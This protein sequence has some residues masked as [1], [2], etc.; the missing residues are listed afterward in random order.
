VLVAQTVPVRLLLPL[1]ELEAAVDGHIALLIKAL[2]GLS[3]VIAVVGVLGLGSTLSMNILERTREL[4]V[5]MALGATPKRLRRWI[6]AEGVAVAVFG[7]VLAGLLSLLVT[8]GLDA[9]IGSL[10][11]MAPLPFVLDGRAPAV[12]LAIVLASAFVASIVPAL[13]LDRLSVREA[14]SEL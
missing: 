12:W 6:V 13:R 4:G 7:W 9:L 2:L 5:M 1:S 11:F 3:L 8:W 10:G 14:L